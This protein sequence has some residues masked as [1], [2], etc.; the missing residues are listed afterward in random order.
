MS[1]SGYWGTKEINSLEKQAK[2]KVN[3]TYF[4]DV[5]CSSQRHPTPHEKTPV[6]DKR[7][8]PA[9]CALSIF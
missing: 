8:K 6:K 3:G 2:K 7:F 5:I 4:L 1:T 9:D